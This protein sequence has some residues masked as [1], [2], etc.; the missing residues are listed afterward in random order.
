[1]NRRVAF[2]TLGCRLNQ[3]ETDSLVT[4]FRRAGYRVVPFSDEA[5]C[6]IMNTCTV[7]DRSDRKSRNLI[8]RATGVAGGPVVVVTGCFVESSHGYAFDRPG[9]TYVVDNQRKHTIFDLVDAHMRGEVGRPAELPA[10]R[11]RF[12][13]AL[14]GFHTRAALKIQDGCDDFCTFCIIPFVRGRAESRPVDDVLEHARRIIGAGAREIVLTGVNMGRYDHDGT[15]FTALVELLL[16]LRGEF[17]LRLSSIEPDFRGDGFERLIAH[18]KLCPHLHLCLQSGS[19][20]VLRRMRRRYTVGDYLDFVDA[21]R[22]CD[23]SFNFT[24]DVIVGF[25]GES[26]DDFA[27]TLDVA[28]TVGFS[29]IHTFPYSRRSGTKAARLPGQVDH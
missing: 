25:P 1:M 2:Q 4:D 12:G 9:V 3:Y 10:D 19:D 26:E 18:E 17:R 5:D 28:R 22:R 20:R 13:D 6:Y 29:H 11:F 16:G 14:D 23:E 15:T 8:N 21:I 24:T 27:R 7:T